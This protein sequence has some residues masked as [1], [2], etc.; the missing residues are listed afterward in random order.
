M[1]DVKAEGTDPRLLEVRTV[2]IISGRGTSV[3]LSSVRCPVRGRSAA[4]EACAECAPGGQ[5]AQDALARGE[6]L[7]CGRRAG[8]RPRAAGPDTVGAVMPRTAIAFRGSVARN[9][10]A[11]VLRARGAPTAPVVDG[12]GRPIG[13]VAESDLL[14]ANPGAR[15]ADAMTRVA[16]AVPEGASVRRA[17]ALM[18]AHGVERLA[19]VGQDGAVVGVIGAGDLVGWLADG[20]APRRP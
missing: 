16:L 7:A 10:A 2:E 18:S 15:V 17:A 8:E 1:N 3:T 4:V 12:E 9:V 13:M 11:D 6:F 5:I 19:V 20:A 14:R